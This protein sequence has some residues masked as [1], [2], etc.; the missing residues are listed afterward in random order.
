[1]DDHADDHGGRHRCLLRRHQP[2]RRL[3]AVAL[4]PPRGRPARRLRAREQAARTLADRHHHGRHRRAAGAGAGGLCRLRAIRRPTSLL[5][6]VLGQQWQWRYRLPGRRRQARRQRRALR[7]AAPTPSAS[8]RPTPRPRTTSLVAGNE[9]HLPLG[10][11]VKVLLRSHDVLH[12]F[13][14]PQFR[15]RMN[16]VPGQVSWF[17]FTPTEAGRYEV[18][19]RAAVRRRP[20]EHARH[21]GGRRRGRLRRPGCSSS[22]PSRTRWPGERRRRRRGRRDPAA[23]RPRAGAGQGLRGLPLGRRQ[24]RRRADLEG[25]V[26]QDRDAGRRLHRAGRR[27]LPARLH[28]RPEG[29]RRSRASRR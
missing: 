1:M 10:Q 7:R 2:V 17:W 26:R 9:V 8:T 18:D 27:G 6:E 19:V 23:T 15:A 25:P 5:L 29:T 22:R 24:P 20:P 11:P 28:P 14:V 16:I 13:F 3:H 21:R 12:D 4:P